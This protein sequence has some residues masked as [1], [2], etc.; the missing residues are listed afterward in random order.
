MLDLQEFRAYSYEETV[1]ILRERVRYAFVP[2]VFDEDAFSTV[3]KRTYD[4]KDLRKGLFLLREAGEI[5]ES[6]SSR[7][8]TLPHAEKALAKLKDFS[9]KKIDTLAPDERR[10][11]EIIDHNIGKTTKQIFDLFVK[12]EEMS[13]SS[14]QR[15]L[16]QLEKGK[17]I[18]LTP[19]NT[20]QPGNLVIV[21][22]GNTTLDE[23]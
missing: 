22:R 5:A 16:K 4:G 3:A 23:F 12:E 7:K 9:I 10:M 15:R 14:F 8:I 1:D 11:L 2:G 6:A 20:G 19:A 17:F 18:T 13:Y 21:Q